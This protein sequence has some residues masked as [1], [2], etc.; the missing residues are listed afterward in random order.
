MQRIAA[1]PS[2]L[3]Q[4]TCN[5]TRSSWPHSIESRII[6]QGSSDDC[7]EMPVFNSWNG[8]MRQSVD[9]AR[10][11][12]TK[13]AFIHPHLYPML[14]QH[15]N[16]IFHSLLFSFKT[17]QHRNNRKLH[18][19]LADDHSRF[20]GVQESIPAIAVRQR[21]SSALVL[22]KEASHQK[23]ATICTIETGGNT[24]HIEAFERLW[25]RTSDTCVGKDATHRF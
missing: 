16:N 1:L 22:H 2:V 4:S 6:G 13:Y 15:V 8:V 3:G 19:T 24:P 12:S 10:L 18:E 9:H 7:A 25:I 5:S 20:V 11:C 21:R 17:A 14:G 23:S